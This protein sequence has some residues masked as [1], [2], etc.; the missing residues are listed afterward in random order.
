M[1]KLI[2]IVYVGKKLISHDNVARSGKIWNGN[3][4]IQEVT[5]QQAK[6]L[7]KYPDQ[8][9]LVDDE[10]QEEMDK[11]EMMRVTDENGEP[12]EIDQKE[13]KKPLEKMSKLELIAL[14]EKNWQKK[15]SQD[16]SKKQ[17]IDEIEAWAAELGC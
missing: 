8:W 5:E 4:D 11:P 10:D 14:A 15:L 2:K 13:L 1:I 12:V 6:I 9:A 7:L 3:G 16:M 17:M